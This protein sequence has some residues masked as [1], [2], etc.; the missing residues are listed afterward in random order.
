M[1]DKISF[2]G[3]GRTHSNLNISNLSLS[4]SGVYFCAAS[5]HSAADSPLVNTKTLLYVE[6]L[7]HLLPAS[8]S[9]SL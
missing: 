9:T 1:K 6:A 2:D 7:E 3:D 5:L 4:D 8:V